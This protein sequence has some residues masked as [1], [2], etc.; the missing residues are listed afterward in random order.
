[1][2]T[3][4]PD[5]MTDPDTGKWVDGLYW[6]PLGGGGGGGVMEC[7]ITT[8]LNAGYFI[9][10]PVAGG[11]AFNCAKSVP[12]RNTAGA[13]SPLDNSQTV[14]SEV[15]IMDPPFTVGDVVYVADSDKT[16][17]TV[18]G[19]ALTKIEMNTKRSWVHLVT[20]PT[21]SGVVVYAP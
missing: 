9:A 11:A 7:K 14:V 13:T 1:M 5:P 21:V 15:Q 18:S 4:P 6:V 10:T 20:T 19:I 2:P 3:A 17:V 16:D 12:S 8:L